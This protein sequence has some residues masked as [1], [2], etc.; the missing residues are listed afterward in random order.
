MK[1]CPKCNANMPDE[2]NFCTEC[3]ADL[4]AAASETE[5][6]EAQSRSVK[7]EV[8]KELKAT[9]T[10]AESTASTETDTTKAGSSATVNEN[11]KDEKEKAS[12]D[13]EQVKQTSMNY[14][15]W[16]LGSWMHPTEMESPALN[17]F[18]ILSVVLEIVLFCLAFFASVQRILTSLSGMAV[19]AMNTLSALTG[20]VS[21][22][23]ENTMHFSASGV[24]IQLFV[25]LL[26]LSAAVL[27]AVYGINCLVFKVREN[28][29]DFINRF[30]HY[31]NAILIVNVLL[32]LFSL[33][34]SSYGWLSLLLAISIFFY[35]VGLTTT[36][37]ARQG[38]QR[39]DRLY[40]AILIVVIVLIAFGILVRMGG[41]AFVYVMKS[42]IGL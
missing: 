15:K 11:P 30:A 2:A 4:T 32:L 26:L 9:T 36:V 23:V 21:S 17:W 14:F 8:E 33:V 5:E 6:K 18:G 29:F 12:L 37:I 22:N 41:T 1:K 19:S 31:T 28:F 42:V 24:S 10:E 34:S 40:G 27:G 7:D 25:I 39:L 35:I 20:N 3:G 38:F 16:V 13:V